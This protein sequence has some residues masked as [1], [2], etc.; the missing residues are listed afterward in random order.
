MEAESSLPHS[1]VPATCPYPEPDQS[2]PCPHPISWKSILILFSHLRLG[3]PSGLFPSDFPAK[4]LY[5]LLHSPT[6]AACPAHP[7]LLDLITRTILGEQHRSLSSSLCSFLH[8]PVTSSLLG[9]NILP[10][11]L[12]SNTLSLRSS[13]NVTDQVSHP[14]K[15]HSVDTQLTEAWVS[16]VGFPEVPVHRLG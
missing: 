7:I 11:T 16:L 6:R 15:Q 9:T 8:S 14:Y 5:M 3:L 10:S 4:P 12:F 1:Q 13:L 2:S